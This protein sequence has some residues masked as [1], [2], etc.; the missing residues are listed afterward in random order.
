MGERGERISVWQCLPGLQVS[1]ASR[2][3]GQSSGSAS[4]RQSYTVHEIVRIMVASRTAGQVIR[5]V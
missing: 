3:N 2:G 1:E 4:Q 5:P